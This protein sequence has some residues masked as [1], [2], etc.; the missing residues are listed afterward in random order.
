VI[1]PRFPCPGAGR[2]N[3]G[4]GV[5]SVPH[6]RA[7]GTGPRRPRPRQRS[8]VGLGLD[9][10]SPGNSGG[11]HGG[12]AR[13][14]DRLRL[15][16]FLGGAHRGGDPRP[17][18]GAADRPLRRPQCARRLEP[19]LRRR[20]CHARGGKFSPR[21][22]RGVARGRLRHGDGTLRSCVLD[23]GGNLRPPSPRGDHRHHPAC[24]VRE[25]HLL[26]DLGL[27]GGTARLAGDML[28]LGR[29]ARV[30]RASP[31]PLSRA[32]RPGRRD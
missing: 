4:M 2:P 1:E 10:L 26:A 6:E 13:G 24:R 5:G 17:A 23:P 28:V 8:N 25:H 15:R 11:P 31:K 20:A 19:R 16:R 22:A 21:P 14:F 3:S 9:L 12:R 32:A 30:R 27:S 18:G 29:R 7:Q